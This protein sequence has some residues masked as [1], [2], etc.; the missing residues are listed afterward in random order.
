MD[1]RLS[2]IFL[3]FALMVEF[4][5]TQDSFGDTV[6]CP[7]YKCD[8]SINSCATMVGDATNGKNVTLNGCSNKTNFEC[9][10]NEK[11]AFDNPTLNIS[12]TEKDQPKR[13]R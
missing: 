7:R 13:T 4:I 11:M 2:S 5:S 9:V 6:M 12:C 10:F 3:V 8:S 1:S